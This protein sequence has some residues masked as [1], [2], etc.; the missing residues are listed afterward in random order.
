MPPLGSYTVYIN[1]NYAQLTAGLAKVRS[2][3]TQQMSTLG[4]MASTA[5]GVAAGLG[6]GEIAS[7]VRSFVGGFVTANAEISQYRVSLGV[8]LQDNKRA[9]TLLTELEQ[10]A[11]S[12]PFE[13][14]SLMK[15]VQVLKAYGVETEKL[16]PMLRVIGDQAAASPEGME[17]GVYLISLALGQMRGAAKGYGQEIRQLINAG[18]PVW[19][20]LSKQAGKSIADTQAAVKAGEISGGQAVEMLL[21]GMA[22]RTGGMMKVQ[23]QEFFGLLSTLK[24]E[25][26]IFQRTAGFPL[27]DLLKDKL[28]G[29]IDYLQSAKGKLDAMD[30]AANFRRILDSVIALASNPAV[31]TGLKFAALLYAGNMVR[32]FL[33]TIK[34][35]DDSILAMNVSVKN[36]GPFFQ[37]LGTNM[38]SVQVRALAL[39]AGIGI[40]TAGLVLLASAYARSQATGETFGESVLRQTNHLLGLSDALK[41]LDQSISDEGKTN[42]IAK[43]IDEATES[44]D[45]NEIAKQR[46]AMGAHAAQIEREIGE[47]H[48]RAAANDA[49][50]NEWA[51]PGSGQFGPSYEEKER[52]RFLEQELKRIEFKMRS[53]NTALSDARFKEESGRMMQRGAKVAGDVNWQGNKGKMADAI[54][55]GD[56][57]GVVGILEQA[58]SIDRD[59]ARFSQSVRQSKRAGRKIDEKFQDEISGRAAARRAEDRARKIKQQ[60]DLVR[61]RIAGRKHRSNFDKRNK[62][63]NKAGQAAGKSAKQNM[64]QALM[65]GNLQSAAEQMN[66]IR[67]AGEK[68]EKT[69]RDKDKK[70]S[71]AKTSGIS[72]LYSSIQN[73]H[74]N[75]GKNEELQRQKEIA[76]N[77]K[78]TADKQDELIGAVK[79]IGAVVS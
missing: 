47:I 63:S 11:A 54:L 70:A 78:K 19:D 49:S 74:L 2:D 68:L 40:V 22:G 37:Q 20:L 15:G 32:Q 36:I 77:T 65:T 29:I 27:F 55:R 46:N 14:G 26:R 21:A 5:F 9:I 67:V 48:A 60:K 34:Q 73:S 52:I 16:I 56:L 6:L 79:N 75:K 66:R 1:A 57:G 13:M 61:A 31:T 38:A 62:W 51:E 7:Q 44:G 35:L 4:T 30:F 42:D 18:V 53:S 58:K 12:T 25:L 45:A 76:A 71:G 10:L 69:E 33:P 8:L 72:E 23:S 3:V 64:F 24:D 50:R 28:A 59:R 43:K 39:N 41:L 17:R